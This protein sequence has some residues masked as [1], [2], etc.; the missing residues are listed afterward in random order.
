[1]YGDPPGPLF[2]LGCFAGLLL[3]GCARW[4]VG[5]WASR[6]AFPPPCCFSLPVMLVADPGQRELGTSPRCVVGLGP[7]VGWW[8]PF[9]HCQGSAGRGGPP[10]RV[11]AS[12]GFLSS[13]LWVLGLA[14]S[15]VSR[16]P[17][18]VARV[19]CFA[20]LAHVCV[21]VCLTVCLSVCL[22]VCLAGC[23]GVSLCA[24]VCLCGS[25]CAWDSVGV[26]VW[27]FFCFFFLLPL[28]P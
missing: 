21:S 8:A 10:R 22:L 7:M 11:C 24:S 19:G 23:P 18:L 20:R 5:P 6:P 4:R 27:F 2:C 26:P 28:D 9:S 16:V 12:C 15:L 25:G 14:L 3:L 17:F 13:L 1:M